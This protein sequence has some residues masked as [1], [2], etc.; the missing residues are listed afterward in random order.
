MR[1][2]GTYDLR[3]DC[4]VA[5]PSGWCGSQGG[6]AKG[7]IGLRSMDR[8]QFD[9][10]GL[11]AGTQVPAASDALLTIGTLVIELNLSAHDGRAVSLL[12]QDETRGWLR[13]MSL[14]LAEDGTLCLELRQGGARCVARLGLPRI[15]QDT[16]LRVSYSWN[17]PARRGLLSAED[18]DLETLYQ[19]EMPSP[20]PLPLADLRQVILGEGHVRLGAG[21]RWIGLSDRIEPVGLSIGVAAGTPV[22]TPDGLRPVERLRLG[23]MVMT[24]QGAMP[25]RWMTRREVPAL[26][27]FRPIHLRAPYHGLSHD[28][29]VAPD[30]RLVVTGAEAEYLFGEDGVLV[31]AHHLVDGRTVRRAHGGGTLW[32]Y[33]LLFDEHVCLS[34]AGM[35]GESLFV[36]AMGRASEL[37]ATTALAGLPADAVPRH[38]A[39]ARPPL[40]SYE[41]RT[42]AASLVA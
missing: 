33:H 21:L 17:A 23:D 38:R 16:R 34:Y 11:C 35:Q 32:Y 25:L 40:S 8:S 36:G 4:R 13:H 30:H 22:E 27:A 12:R 3:A 24:S 31:E 42:L 20:L 19:V 7:W 18:L 2:L 6:G 9:P 1:D 5:G 37:V 39:F 28:I 15:A 26:G 14:I 10:R 29:L 41:A